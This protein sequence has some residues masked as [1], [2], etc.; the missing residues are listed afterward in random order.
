MKQ[1][2]KPAS[3]ILSTT[4]QG[5]TEIT[6]IPEGTDPMELL[7]QVIH[8][9]PDCQAAR[10]RGE[11]IQVVHGGPV[12]TDPTESRQV[13]RANQRALDRRRRRAVAHSKR[14]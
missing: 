8:D 11:R 3:F 4:P 5:D 10:A 9:C 7:E 14:N 12:A 2:Q 1:K 13:R 6:P